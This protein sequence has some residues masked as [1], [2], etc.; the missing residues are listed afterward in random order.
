MFTVTILLY[1]S[2]LN[3]TLNCMFERVSFL[4]FWLIVCTEM[5]HQN[6]GH[7]SLRSYFQ[8]CQAFKPC[9]MLS[10]QTFDPHLLLGTSTGDDLELWWSKDSMTTGNI[11]QQVPQKQR[12]LTCCHFLLNLKELTHHMVPDYWRCHRLVSLEFDM[13]TAAAFM[14]LHWY[15]SH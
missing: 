9:Q 6:S 11:V 12:L 8:S 5:S 1:N 10:A 4:F 7:F 2:S 3:L 13:K 14:P 15:D